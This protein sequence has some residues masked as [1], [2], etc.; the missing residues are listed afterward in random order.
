[1]AM[2]G[3]NFSADRMSDEYLNYLFQAKADNRHVRRIA[4]WLGLL[5]LGIEKIKDK[6]WVSHTRQLCFEVDKTRYKVKY[7]HSAGTRGGI[8]FVEIEAAP[9]QPEIHTA[10]TILNLEDAAKFYRRPTL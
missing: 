4:S 9:G 1:M 3:E 8:E 10:R 6:W 5:I 2:K 7:S